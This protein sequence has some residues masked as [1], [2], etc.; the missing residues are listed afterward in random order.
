MTTVKDLFEN[1]ELMN[2]I[3]EDIEDIPADAEVFYAVWAL[4][5]D[6][7]KEPTDDEVLVGEFTDPDAAVEQAEKVT[8]ELVNEMGFGEPN[9][10]TAYFSVEVETVVGDPDDEDGGTMN[11]GTVYQRDLWIDGEYGSVEE[12]GLEDSDSVISITDKDFKLLE[13]GTMKISCALLKNFN[14]NDYVTFEFPEEDLVAFL[15][16]KIVSKVKYEDGDYYHCE[17]QL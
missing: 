9:P 13:D 8:I 1:E 14:K 10:N 16:Y 7:D 3:V 6:K 12:A 17:V 15:T 2:N 11:I 4:G 5:Y